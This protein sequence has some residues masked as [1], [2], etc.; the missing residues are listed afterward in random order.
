MPFRVKFRQAGGHTHIRIFVGS[1]PTGWAL[2]GQL[3]LRPD[4]A[5]AFFRVLQQG[6]NGPLDSGQEVELGVE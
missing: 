5:D 2:A 3:V 4:E 1:R 6:P